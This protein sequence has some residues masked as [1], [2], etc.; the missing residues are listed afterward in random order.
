MRI[1]G[2]ANS[3]QET[4]GKAGELGSKFWFKAKTC[5]QSLSLHIRSEHVWVVAVVMRLCVHER[6][7]RAYLFMKGQST[8][9]SMKESSPFANGSI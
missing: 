4:S 1:F 6:K 9:W 2:R 3:M 8:G 5:P 7:M